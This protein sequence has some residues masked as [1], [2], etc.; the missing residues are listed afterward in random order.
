MLALARIAGE[1]APLLFTIL[2]NSFFPTHKIGSLTV[3]SLNSPI[4]ALPLTIY[5]DSQLPTPVL[6]D[7]AW[8]AAIILIL[9]ILVLSIAAR[10]ATRGSVLE[11]K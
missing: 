7:Y 2:G 9:L 8:A 10:Y 6:N 1:T 5:N 4:D 11:E 3:P